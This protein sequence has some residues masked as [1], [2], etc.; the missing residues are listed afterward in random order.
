[1]LDHVL[2]DWPAAAPAVI[3]VERDFRAAVAFVRKTKDRVVGE[4]STED[5]GAVTF[6]VVKPFD[7]ASAEIRLVPLGDGFLVVAVRHPNQATGVGAEPVD[8]VVDDFVEV[9]VALVLRADRR[10]AAAAV[11][12]ALHDAK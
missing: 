6:V 5:V 11:V 10:L 3:G 2:G 9:A 7:E 12:A 1:V 4:G 8:R